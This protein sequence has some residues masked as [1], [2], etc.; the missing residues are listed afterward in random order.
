VCADRIDCGGRQCQA[1]TTLADKSSGNL[2]RALLL[3]LKR[4]DSEVR[5]MMIALAAADLAGLFIVALVGHGGIFVIIGSWLVGIAIFVV[6]ARRAARY[7]LGGVMWF[8]VTVLTFEGWTGMVSWL[9]I[10]TGW[11]SGNQPAYRFTITEVI[12]AM[13]LFVGI[14]LMSRR[15]SA[16]ALE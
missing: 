6:I 16:A 4:A 10:W 14:W 7:S 11:W 8:V 5:R 15:L 13:P 1:E 12:G 9:S 3:P 2:F